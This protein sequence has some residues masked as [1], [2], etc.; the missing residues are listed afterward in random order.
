MTDDFPLELRQF[1]DR[2]VESIVQLETL[3]LLRR[4]PSRGWN[5]DQIAKSLYI[6]AEMSR[7][8]IADLSGRGFVKPLPSAEAMY[9]YQP[10]DPEADLLI[11]QLA[12]F[13]DER[14][15]AVISL[16]YS[17]PVN[18]VQTFADAFRLRKET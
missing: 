17:K 15:V 14:R 16:I 1:I 3:L 5:A 18:K 4:D 9:S 11:G 6:S 12:K 7:A 2:N 13:Y 8:L 10:A